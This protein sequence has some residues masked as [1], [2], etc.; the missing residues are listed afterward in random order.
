[1]LICIFLYLFSCFLLFFSHPWLW[2]CRELSRTC[3]LFVVFQLFC[4]FVFTCIT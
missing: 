3:F 2:A 1:L 4:R